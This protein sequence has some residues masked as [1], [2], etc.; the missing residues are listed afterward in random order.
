MSFRRLSLLGVLALAGFLAFGCAG[1]RVGGVG[2]KSIQGVNSVYV[3]VL[4]N[5]T[6]EPT[7]EVPTTTAIIRAFDKDGTL[8]TSQSN[9]ADSQLDVT[10]I[11]VR[12]SILTPEQLDGQAGNQFEL[13]LVA[14]VTFINR[15]LGKKILD[16]VVVQ[17]T[18]SYFVN[19]DQVE[20]ERQA[21]PMAEESLAKNIV[22]LVTEGW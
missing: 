8:A 11:D 6:L 14:R 4:K 20:G 16:D 22:A 15:K 1:Y 13:T 5:K 7:L 9:G 3:P 18:N 19:R 21:L 12:R 17:G 2:G 10:I